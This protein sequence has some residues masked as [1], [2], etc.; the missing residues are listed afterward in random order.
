[1][2]QLTL[3]GRIALDELRRLQG[4][5]ESL[6]WGGR[7]PR[8]LTRAHERFRLRLSRD[9]ADLDS[10]DRRIDEQYLR[11]AKGEPEDPFF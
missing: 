2:A 4:L 6:P 5:D 8:A 3:A 10:D 11:F 9:D 7:S 1:M